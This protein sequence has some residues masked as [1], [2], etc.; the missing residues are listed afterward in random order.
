MESIS[1]THTVLFLHIHFRLLTPT[2]IAPRF[3]TSNMIVRRLLSC[4]LETYLTR[5]GHNL[6]VP[7]SRMSRDFSLE[8]GLLGFIRQQLGYYLLFLVNDPHSPAFQVQASRSSSLDCRWTWMGAKKYECPHNYHVDV[9]W[10]DI[11]VTQ[12]TLGKLYLSWSMQDTTPP[13]LAPLSVRL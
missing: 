12:G 5:L 11:E 10:L 3:R 8:L 13:A 2:L 4:L 7:R 1:P 6:V 9:Y